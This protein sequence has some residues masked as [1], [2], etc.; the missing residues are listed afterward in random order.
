MQGAS[1]AGLGEG[2]QLA[3]A[4]GLPVGAA[5]SRRTLFPKLGY[6]EAQA[7]L[8]VPQRPWYAVGPDRPK[9]DAVR[10]VREGQQVVREGREQ[11]LGLTIA[12]GIQEPG[13]PQ[14]GIIN[15]QNRITPTT[16]GATTIKPILDA[17]VGQANRLVDDV[18]SMAK[19][20]GKYK[21]DLD[22]AR[23]MYE[24]FRS[25]PLDGIS[26]ADIVRRLR[27]SPLYETRGTEQH[28]FLSRVIDMLENQ[29]T[30]TIPASSQVTTTMQNGLPILGV[31]QTP[32][33]TVPVPANTQGQLLDI[34]QQVS[35]GFPD[36]PGIRQAVRAEARTALN[37]GRT[38]GV[39]GV[40][41]QFGSARDKENFVKRLEEGAQTVRS[42]GDQDVV[43][44]RFVREVRGQPGSTQ[45][46]EWQDALNPT[47]FELPDTGHRIAQA[48]TLLERTGYGRSGARSLDPHEYGQAR[49]SAASMGTT[50][51]GLSGQR[52]LLAVVPPLREKI[53][54]AETQKIA[55]A[56]ADPTGKKLMKLVRYNPNDE[57]ARNILLSLGIG[58]GLENAPTGE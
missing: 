31:T 25:Q 56:L 41:D 16:A 14:S 3:I 42:T 52:R 12:Q 37:E 15:L 44:A 11:G 17:Q 18:I 35:E 39:R 1:D 33:K 53:M 58:Y 47:Q 27:N 54:A 5:L 32:A 49:A 46:Q 4:F 29:G 57:M 8:G 13:G 34:R 7:A 24:L 55:E 10:Q 50:A 21:N 9:R 6:D 28:K 51:A 36:Q 26:R 30:T 22:Q 38:M 48:L 19:E 23:A 45:R 2:A 40:D 43:G 20:T